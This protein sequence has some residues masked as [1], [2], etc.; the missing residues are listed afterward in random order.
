MKALSQVRQSARP[1]DLHRFRAADV[2]RLAPVLLVLVSL[3]LF[4]PGSLR[5]QGKEQDAGRQEAFAE[6]QQI[7]RQLAEIR[8]EALQ[9]EEIAA[10]SGRLQE[11]MAAAMRKADPRANEKRDRLD[12]LRTEMREAQEA[13]NQSK[14][15]R[16]MDEAQELQADLQKAQAEAMQD[17]R[18]SRSIEKV[19]KM[20]EKKMKEIN[21]EVGKLLSREEK[22]TEELQG[23]G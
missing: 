3:P 10:E 17:Q 21:P 5:A 16:L 6:L 20:L 19:Q 8:Q 7:R 4:A 2:R 23:K 11:M 1:A 15:T 18:I 12:D 13:G 22:L 9:D 14:I